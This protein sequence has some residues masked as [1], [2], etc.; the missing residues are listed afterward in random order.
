MCEFC[1]QH[2]EGKKWYEI[3]ENYSREFLEKE[4]R[5]NYISHFV[6][7]VRGK[8]NSNIARLEWAK[9]R[10]P[11]ADRFIRS[12]GTRRMKKNHFGQVVPLEDAERIVEMVQTVT[13]VACICRNVATGSHTCRYCLLLGID[14][15]GL[16][17]D[18]PEIESGLEG[19][20]VDEAKELLREFHREGLVHSIWTFET[21]FIGAI[22]NCNRDC[23]A[24]RIQV[25]K[26]L[27]TIMFKAEYMAEIDPELCTGC[28]ACLDLCQFD[29]LDYSA[30]DKKCT[31]NTGR[32]YGCGTCRAGCKKDAITLQDK[33][34]HPHLQ[35]L[36]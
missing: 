10:V 24:Y 4:S 11:L 15:T 17:K 30:T 20:T 7:N 9:K 12:I 26:D 5:R 14:P 3:M 18:W 22:C 34:H 23:L 1:V 21:P 6:P 19:L 33:A 8:A 29:A 36:W 31:V 35:G 25:E 2:G 13:R 27:L 28:R 32:C 16:V